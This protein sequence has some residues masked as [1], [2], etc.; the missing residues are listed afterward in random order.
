MLFGADAGIE[1]AD[2][3]TLGKDP[4]AAFFWRCGLK[5]FWVAILALLTI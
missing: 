4:K 3:L 2:R 5:G 1:T